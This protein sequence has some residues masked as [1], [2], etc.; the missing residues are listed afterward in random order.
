MTSF[1]ILCSVIQEAEFFILI[2]SN[3]NVFFYGLGFWSYSR[4]SAELKITKTFS[5]IKKKKTLLSYFS[6]LGLWYI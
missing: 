5:Y 3:I 1:F 4:N 2:K 6:F